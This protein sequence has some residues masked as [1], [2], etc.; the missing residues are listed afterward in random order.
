MLYSIVIPTYNHCDDLLK[1]CLESIFR[2]SF[3]DTI[4]LI[5]VANG[6][7]DNT[8]LY[9]RDLEKK[10]NYLGLNKNIKIL[11]SDDPLGYAAATNLGIDESTCEFVLLLNNDV[12]ILDYWAKNKWL[13]KLAE[14]FSENKNIGIT[15]TLLQYSPIINDNFVIFFCAMIRK[16]VFDSIGTLCVDFKI[17]SHEDIDFC[18]RAQLAGWKIES[19]DKNMQWSHELNTNIGQFPMY[20]KGEGTVNDTQ[21]VQNWKKIFDDNALL[22]AQKYNIDYA[23]KIQYSNTNL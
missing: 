15:G 19:V 8:R 23:N 20:H 14:P 6:C 18:H 16:Q 1:P 2:N 22:L 11:W 9:L 3:I 5:I 7:K 17:G 21:L 10:F 12:V 13:E 4:E